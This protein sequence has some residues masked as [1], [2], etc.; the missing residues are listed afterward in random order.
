[1]LVP[2]VRRDEGQC[3]GDDLAQLDPIDIGRSLDDAMRVVARE[4][5]PDEMPRYSRCLVLGCP[6]CPEYME[7]RFL[8]VFGRECRVFTALPFLEESTVHPCIR[9][10]GSRQRT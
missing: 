3:P 2:R 9:Q 5:G 10:M 6:V 8:E 4:V 1:M 7:D